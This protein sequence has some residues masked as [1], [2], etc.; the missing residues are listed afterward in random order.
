[1]LEPGVAALADVISW[2]RDSPGPD[3]PRRAS[4]RVRRAGAVL[5]GLLAA[6]GLA[7][8]LTRPGAAGRRAVPAPPSPTAVPAPAGPPPADH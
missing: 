7:I 5:A 1:V 8:W 3:P 2:G 6:A 4:R